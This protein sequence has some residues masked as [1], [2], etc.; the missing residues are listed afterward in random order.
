[1]EMNLNVIAINDL[2]N[3]NGNKNENEND[4]WG[5]DFRSFC[6]NDPDL[7]GQ[8]D[9]KRIKREIVP[10]QINNDNDESNDEDDDD[11]SSH[12]SAFSRYLKEEIVYAKSSEK[13]EDEF[14]DQLSVE[15]ENENDFDYGDDDND[16]LSENSN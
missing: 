4:Y 15:N 16:K 13:D 3:E 9:I 11:E 10:D 7:N 12:A 14:D 5:N 6:E 1:M 8:N 2:Q